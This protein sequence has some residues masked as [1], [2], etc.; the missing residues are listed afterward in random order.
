MVY[1][2]TIVQPIT[3][4]AYSDPV[5]RAKHGYKEEHQHDNPMRR[6]RD[7]KAM[8]YGTAAGMPN[9]RHA[10]PFCQLKNI[11]DLKN[12]QHNFMFKY[13]RTFIFGATV[14]FVYGAAWTFIRPMSGMAIQKLMLTVGERD[15]SGRF[16]R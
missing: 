3:D 4:A 9:Y 10:E 15:W 14:G 12:E 7:F 13:I 16:G 11:K 5:W 2:N 8:P 6:N 1:T